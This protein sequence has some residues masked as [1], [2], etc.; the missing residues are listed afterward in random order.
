MGHI[1]SP[2]EPRHPIGVVSTRTG[3][4]QD[5]LRAWE[6]RYAAVVPHR[7]DT[8]RRLYTD[9]D[10]EKLRL[11]RLAVESGR[12]ISDVAA[13]DVAELGALVREDHE[14]P[15]APL[16]GAAGGAGAAALLERALEAVSGLDAR[17]LEEVLFDASVE[18]PATSL[19]GDV[20]QPLLERLGD[21]WRSGS[22][23]IAHEHL[24]SAVV[25]SF[26]GALRNGHDARPG[27]PVVVVTTPSGQ[28]HEI[29]ALL[30][31]MAATEVGWEALYLGP[32]LPANEIAAVVRARGARAVAL[33]LVWP[34]ADPAV[35]GELQDLRRLVGPEVALFAGGSGAASYAEVLQEV[36][37][38]QVDEGAAFQAALDALLR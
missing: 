4:P 7:T 18:L 20:V 29:G 25:R 19:R 10:L 5:V 30:A 38:V 6:R 36:G 21:G 14:S 16:R 24:A 23:R 32:H 11:L 34:P 8:G 35:R 2:Q 27:A 9:G 31:A 13:L 1:A 12:R 22:T 26:L 15:G 33:S 17:R 28:R 3:L 37:A